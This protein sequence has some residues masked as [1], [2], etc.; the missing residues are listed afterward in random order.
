[1]TCSSEKGW[2]ERDII[3]RPWMSPGLACTFVSGNGKLRANVSV[4]VLLET[5]IASIHACWL[6]LWNIFHFS[7]LGIMIPTDS[8]FSQ[9]G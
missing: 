3:S 9:R 1:M 8:Y 6:V 5:M 7:I 4:F 2:F